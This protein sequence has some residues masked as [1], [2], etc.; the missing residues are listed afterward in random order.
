[1]SEQIEPI[2]EFGPFP[3]VPILGLEGKYA[4]TKEGFAWNVRKN[5]PLALTTCKDG[6]LR[7]QMCMNGKPI[8][9]R[10]HRLV[11]PAFYGEI[12]SGLQINH[13]DGNKTNNCLWNLELVSQSEN[14]RH[15]YKHGLMR[16]KKGERNGAAKLT[17]DLV[18]KI[19]DALKSER[20]S[21]SL[22][23]EYRMSESQISNI[24]LGISWKYLRGKEEQ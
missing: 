19:I 15:A 13:L 2:C 8:L 18:L 5:R 12:P 9:G 11:W 21:A 1:M 20:T 7:A 22:A 3:L 10:V 17:E 16:P 24:K 23:R 6:Y 4:I 14:L